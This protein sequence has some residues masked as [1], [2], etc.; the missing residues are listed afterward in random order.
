MCA[1]VRRRVRER[2]RQTRDQGAPARGGRGPPS[3]LAV[4]KKRDGFQGVACM[5]Y[6]SLPDV[7]SRRGCGGN[8]AKANQ[9]ICSPLRRSRSSCF[10][11]VSLWCAEQG[12]SVVANLPK[13]R[14]SERESSRDAGR[15]KQNE[16]DEQEGR[17]RYILCRLC[18]HSDRQIQSQLQHDVLLLQASLV[19][20][21]GFQSVVPSCARLI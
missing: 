20:A 4:W 1:C 14:E 10:R 13:G 5:C 17:Y 7:G 16:T 19:T 3:P 11:G 2:E 12:I 8:K 18:R 21:F 6:G 9:A 15:E